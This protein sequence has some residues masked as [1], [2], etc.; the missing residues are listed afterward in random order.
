VLARRV[1]SKNFGGQTFVQ[2]LRRDKWIQPTILQPSRRFLLNSFGERL[3]MARRY[4][5]ATKKAPNP[6]DKHVG[7]RVRVRRKMLRMIV[8]APL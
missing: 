5:V 3:A 2:K 8:R 7:S 6:T 4:T 1:I